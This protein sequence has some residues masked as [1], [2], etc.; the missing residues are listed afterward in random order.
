MVRMSTL[1]SRLS[2]GTGTTLTGCGISAKAYASSTK[3]VSWMLVD[4]IAG[5]SLS[6]WAIIVGI[7]CTVITCAVNWYYRRKEREDRLNGH[8]SGNKK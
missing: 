8:V 7:A 3:E 5:L 2:Y 4:K 6:D 1:S